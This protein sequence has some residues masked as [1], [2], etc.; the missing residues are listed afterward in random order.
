MDD[1]EG[2]LQLGFRHRVILVELSLVLEELVALE[3]QQE[4]GIQTV[5]LRAAGTLIVDL[6]V[7][8][9]RTEVG[10]QTGVLNLALQSFRNPELD[11]SFARILSRTRS[12]EQLQDTLLT[13]LGRR[14]SATSL[15]Q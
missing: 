8:G 6:R 10:R 11:L 3:A 13:K 5:D 4:V 15:L 2:L 9:I 1:R 14:L 7:D 12:L